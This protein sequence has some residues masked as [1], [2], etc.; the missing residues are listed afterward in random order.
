VVTLA[1]SMTLFNDKI[2]IA[3]G[4]GETK[5]PL[6]HFKTVQRIAKRF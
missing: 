5:K 1:V 4:A 2:K 6:Q 3:S